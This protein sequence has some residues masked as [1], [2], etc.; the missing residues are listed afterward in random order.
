MFRYKH[1]TL[2]TFYNKKDFT[3]SQRS[4]NIKKYWFFKKCKNSWN[5]NYVKLVSNRNKIINSTCLFTGRVS[6]SNILHFL[7]KQ[8][9]KNLANNGALSGVSRSKR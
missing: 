8:K 1:K 3:K 7:N 5:Y 6:T 4:I 2:K 9:F